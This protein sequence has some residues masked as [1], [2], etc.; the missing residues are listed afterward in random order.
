MSQTQLEPHNGATSKVSDLAGATSDANDEISR[1]AR[2]THDAFGGT[3]NI[4]EKT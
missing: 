2:A 3:Q 4:T 1:Q